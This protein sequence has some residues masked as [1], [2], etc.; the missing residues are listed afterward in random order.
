[1]KEVMDKLQEMN[2]HVKSSMWN[3]ML[4]VQ[5]DYLPQLIKEK[6]AKKHS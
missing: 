2:P 5:T 6:D 1:M 4:N 3:A